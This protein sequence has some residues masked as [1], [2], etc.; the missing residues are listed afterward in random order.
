MA[1]REE[2]VQREREHELELRRI[3]SDKKERLEDDLA[4]RVDPS[5]AATTVFELAVVKAQLKTP[6]VKLELTPDEYLEALDETEQWYLSRGYKY[7]YPERLKEQ[8]AHWEK[9]KI[10]G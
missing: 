5:S 1:W 2:A 8:R 4:K 6:T 7:P 3:L 10:E 9:R